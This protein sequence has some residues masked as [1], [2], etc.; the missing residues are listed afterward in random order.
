METFRVSPKKVALQYTDLEKE[1]KKVES[2]PVLSATSAVASSSSSSSASAD[3]V[4]NSPSKMT[5]KQSPKPKGEAPVLSEGK[6]QHEEKRNLQL[7]D[8]EEYKKKLGVIGVT[9]IEY[10]P[11]QMRLLGYLLKRKRERNKPE[12]LGGADPA[13][14]SSSASVVTETETEENPARTN[15]PT[16]TSI[17]PTGS[18]D[19]VLSTKKTKRKKKK[20]TDERLRSMF[21][22]KRLLNQSNKKQQRDAWVLFNLFRRLD[23]EKNCDKGLKL[24]ADLL[25]NEN[26][27]S[28]YI[29]LFLKTFG[30]H[31][32]VV[33]FVSGSKQENETSTAVIDYV[34]PKLEPPPSEPTRWKTT[35]M[36]D[37]FA[38]YVILKF[39]WLNN[40]KGQ[41]KYKYNK[42]Y[43]KNKEY[44]DPK[45]VLRRLSR[46]NIDD[47]GEEIMGF[48]KQEP[49]SSEMD[50]GE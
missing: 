36:L 29:F 40:D 15:M 20:M 17:L 41:D 31:Q 4:S 16:N 32:Y 10:G 49:T 13:S 38:G 11:A 25:E 23:V 44:T 35:K 48:K 6:K 26:K 1:V 33:G 37:T 28:R 21:A 12:T 14:S 50:S 30:K 19:V 39:L 46:F 9:M 24:V 43:Y 2:D 5:R 34:C 42:V 45:E 27:P 22:E 47:F 3:S 18:P 7:A 8:L